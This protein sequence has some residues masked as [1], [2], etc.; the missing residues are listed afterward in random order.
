MTKKCNSFD[1]LIKL[2]YRQ[3]EWVILCFSSVYNKI[4]FAL[5]YTEQ[6]W[7]FPVDALI[8]EE[9]FCNIMY[10]KV[11]VFIVS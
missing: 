2:G 10:K 5:F 4:L 6:G 7:G 1:S 11:Y 8:L 3:K 9:P